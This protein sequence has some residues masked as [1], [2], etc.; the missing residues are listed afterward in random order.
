VRLAV[1][2][3]FDGSKGYGQL[4]YVLFCEELAVVVIHAKMIDVQSGIAQ[5][6]A[7]LHTAVEVPKFSFLFFDLFIAFLYTSQF[8]CIT[9]QEGKKRKHSDG[10]PMC[11]A[12]YGIVTTANEWRFLSWD[13]RSSTPKVLLSKPYDCLFNNNVGV[14]E[15]LSVIIRI[16]Q[17]QADYIAGQSV[18][19]ETETEERES[20]RRR[21]ENEEETEE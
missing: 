9:T 4:D 21:L 15:V 1:E 10:N 6:I 11:K 13:M 2:E 17:L 16:L 7:Q 18:K 5:N 3:Q 8:G 14:S 12:M 19:E 20:Q